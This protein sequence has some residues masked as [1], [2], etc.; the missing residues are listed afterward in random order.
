MY[1]YTSELR[2]DELGICQAETKYMFG[3]NGVQIVQT[4][5]LRSLLDDS[6]LLLFDT[7]GH[8]TYTSK[9]DV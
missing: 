8:F 9:N 4:Y 5:K 2:A 7:L 1:K 3:N 6:P